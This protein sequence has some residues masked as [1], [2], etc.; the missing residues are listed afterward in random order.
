MLDP[1]FRPASASPP[2]QSCCPQCDSELA[3]LSVIGGRAGSE[4]WAMR[5]TECGGIH[6]DI[7]RPAPAPHRA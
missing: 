2:V 3:V 4:Y 5:C 7:V 6:L 1:E